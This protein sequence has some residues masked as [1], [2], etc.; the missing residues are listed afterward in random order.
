M[1]LLSV[2][3]HRIQPLNPLSVSSRVSAMDASRRILKATVALCAAFLCSG[4]GPGFA[5]EAVG[6]SLRG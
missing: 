6:D 3:R 4:S 1:R 2:L 5:Q